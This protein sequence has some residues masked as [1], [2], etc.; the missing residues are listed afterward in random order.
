MLLK[1]A[2]VGILALQAFSQQG[3]VEKAFAEYQRIWRTADKDGIARLTSDDL[4]WITRGGRALNKQEFVQIFNPK[5]GT[6][7]IRDMKIRFYG[8][9]AVMT[10]AGEEGSSG[11]LR[12]I[13]WNKT[14]DGWRIVSVQATALQQ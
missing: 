14:P 3:D 5:S 8:D 2:A 11:V 6:R 4:V 12:T 13:V 9:V 1:Y 7:N 10:Y